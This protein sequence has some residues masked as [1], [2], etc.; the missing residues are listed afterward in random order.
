MIR[1][2]DVQSVRITEMDIN[3]LTECV[4]IGQNVWDDCRDCFRQSLCDVDI[5]MLQMLPVIN[6]ENEIICYAYQDNE[7]NRE[8]RMLKELET[9]KDVLQFQD[10]FPEIR[11]VIIYGCNELSYYFS[12]YLERQQINVIVRGRWWD[13]FGYDDAESAGAAGIGQMIIYAEGTLPKLGDLYQLIIRSASP[14]FECIDKIYEA[15][16]QEGKV[17]D[18]EEGV[19]QI[20]E[21]I[22]GK[23]VILLGT[24]V[25]TQDAYD[26]LYQQG[27]DISC[28]ADWETTEHRTLLGKD[29]VHISEVICNGENRIFIDAVGQN[30]ALGTRDMDFFDYYGYERNKQYFLLRDYTDIPDSN[31]I[32]VLKGRTV[33]LAGEEQLC[34]ILSDYLREVEGGDIRTDYMELSQYITMKQTDIFC[35]VNIQY[36]SMMQAEQENPKGCLFEEKLAAQ[37][38]IFYTK[39]FS[40]IRPFILIDLYRNREKEKYA[41]KQFIP[42]GILLGKIPIV[43]GNAFFRGI[44]DGHPDILKMDNMFFN[45]NLFTY[46]IRLANEK[47]E[48]VINAFRKIYDEELTFQYG[49]DDFFKDRFE[50]YINELLLFKEQFTSQELFIIFHV[51]Y[52]E[53]LSGREIADLQ[54]KII[55]WEPHHFPREEFTFLARWLEDK[56][57][58]GQTIFM[59]RD[60]IVSM[61]S[62]YK[63]YIG[64]FSAHGFVS[65]FSTDLIMGTDSEFCQYWKEFHV[66]FED[67]KLH[68][69]NELLKICDRLDISWSDTMLDTTRNGSVFEW[70]GISGFDLKPVFNKYEEYL[71]EFDRFRISLISSVYQKKYGYTYADYTQFTRKELQE[72]FLKEF[73]F[74]KEIQFVQQKD[75]MTYFFQTYHLLRCQLWEMRRHMMWDDIKSEFG[76]VRIGES[77]EKEQSGSGKNREE[78]ERLVQYVRQQ[79]KLV[80]Y[81][82]GR[83]CE[84][85]LGCLGETEQLNLLFCD[86][87]AKYSETFFHGKKVFRPGELLKK[88]QDYKILVTSSRYYETIERN[89]KNLGVTQDRIVCNR[90]QLWD[91]EV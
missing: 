85:L 30:S 1:F 50:K 55:Y 7:A 21:K 13:G 33:V 91:D 51:C 32:H 9:D 61:G 73:R 29:V 24:D 41:I 62:Y 74:Q 70:N 48:N 19:N 88:Y 71:S 58:N 90:F 69:R 28:F 64:K 5:G 11:N 40:R 52:T 81:G 16:V 35:V 49:I 89:L 39:Y 2:C 37:K 47:S 53:L 57:I 20:F 77:R 46:C 66:R 68:P 6:E 65:E 60:G 4:K 43:S 26:L 80:L 12:R 31:L 59:H 56:H 84:A 79:E 8:L 63:F 10:I 38:N 18:T 87:K 15:N 82:I 27:I 36:A 23:E 83:D 67:V 86:M 44:L 17:K 42:K 45:S 3:I 72:M 14:E 76:E 22:R 34:R 75:R 25:Q 54:Q 78:L